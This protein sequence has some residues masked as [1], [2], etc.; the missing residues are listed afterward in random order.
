MTR[1]LLLGIGPAVLSGVLLSAF[2]PSIALG[3]DRRPTSPRPQPHPGPQQ[4]PRPR[5][6]PSC[7]RTPFPRPMPHRME[8]PDR[9]YEIS[10]VFVDADRAAIPAVSAFL[11]A[12]SNSEEQRAGLQA[13]V[14]RG[15]PILH[16]SE[17]PALRVRQDATVLR[18]LSAPDVRVSAYPHLNAQCA[19]AVDF[20]VEQAPPGG[21]RPVT[22][23]YISL[24][25]ENGDTKLL[26]D[27]ARPDG[28]RHLLYA[29]VFFPTRPAPCPRRAQGFTTDFHRQ[30]IIP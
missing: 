15:G 25:F 27:T 24:V 18:D 29:T 28:T 10:L 11:A 21:S 2:L 23:A 9:T 13:R 5:R 20:I 26:S 14:K 6:I 4:P 12:T 17:G 3:L 1:K 7:R 19:E 22:N 8:K 16:I 30:E